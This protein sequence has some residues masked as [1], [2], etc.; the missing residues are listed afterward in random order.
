MTLFYCKILPDSIRQLLSSSIF[1]NRMSL[2]SQILTTFY[3]FV[4]ITQKSKMLEKERTPYFQSA[5]KQNHIPS[6]QKQFL[7]GNFCL[8]V[9]TRKL[10]SILCGGEEGEGDK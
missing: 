5:Q 2:F 10:S 7:K 9:K 4:T 6:Y 8:F 1:P 3:Y